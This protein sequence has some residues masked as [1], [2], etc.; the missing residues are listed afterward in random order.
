GMFARPNGYGVGGS[1]VTIGGTNPGE[2]NIISGNTNSGIG[3]G[4]LSTILGNYIGLSA[5]G[6]IA[7]PNGVGISMNG[8]NNT[9]GG[10]ASGAR[11][12]ISGNGGGISITG[13]TNN[14]SKGNRVIGNYIGTN[15]AG[16]AA[17]A[18]SSG[19]SIGNTQYGVQL[20]FY[21]Y[22]D[23]IGGIN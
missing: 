2:R 1:N 12:I 14:S 22:S 11:N 19:H 10:T 15:P 5:D 18:D 13:S 23:T 17:I 16:T 8:S 7:I 21:A 3:V 9:V 6:T 4:D 20:G